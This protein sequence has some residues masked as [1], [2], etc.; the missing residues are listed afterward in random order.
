MDVA[1]LKSIPLL[2]SF[3]ADDLRKIA[4]FAEEHSVAKVRPS[5]ARATTPTT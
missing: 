2:Q 1:R 5:C 3:S 4:P